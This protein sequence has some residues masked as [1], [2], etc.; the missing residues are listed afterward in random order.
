MVSRVSEILNTKIEV[1][2]DLNTAKSAGLQQIHKIIE[3]TNKV[4][5]NNPIS[6]KATR[7]E[8]I[9]TIRWKTPLSLTQRI[10]TMM[11]SGVKDSIIP[12]INNRIK[13]KRQVSKEL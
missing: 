10:E 7:R 12:S 1:M 8:G 4:I 5:I 13:M 11:P 9:L 3:S 2:S 6:T